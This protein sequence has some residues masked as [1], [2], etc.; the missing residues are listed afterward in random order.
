MSYRVS[1]RSFMLW[2]KI[3][4]LDAFCG[5]KNTQGLIIPSTSLQHL[6]S[7]TMSLLMHCYCHIKL[8]SLMQGHVAQ[9]I[10]V[11]TMSHFPRI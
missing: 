2:P 5:V 8:M 3:V 10:V 1:V 11:A 4:I 6:K 9:Q 7:L